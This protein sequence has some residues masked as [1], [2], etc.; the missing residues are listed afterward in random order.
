MGSSN[1]RRRRRGLLRH[2]GTSG[3]VVCHRQ[4]DALFTA[5]RCSG[6]AIHERGSRDR[7]GLQVGGEAE[8]GRYFVLGDRQSEMGMLLRD[9]SASDIH[10]FET[11]FAHSPFSRQ[12]HTNSLDRTNLRGTLGA[13][14]GE[15]GAISVFGNAIGGVHRTSDDGA[16]ALDVAAASPV[17]NVGWLGIARPSIT[18]AD[19]AADRVERYIYGA[20]A[21]LRPVSLVALHLAA[22]A[23]RSDTHSE[24]LDPGFAPCAAPQCSISRETTEHVA[25]DEYAG[26]AGATATIPMGRSWVLRSD[27]GIQYREQR[28]LDTAISGNFPTGQPF[29]QSAGGFEE[30]FVDPHAIQRGVYAEEAATWNGRL[31]LTAAVHAEGPHGLLGKSTQGFP[32]I[33][34]SWIPYSHDMDVVRVHGAYGVSGELPIIQALS[35]QVARNSFFTGSFLIP[36]PAGM[37]YVH[38]GEVGVDATVARGRISGSAT[39]YQRSINNMALPFPHFDDEGFEVESF[40]N[41]TTVEN[42]SIELSLDVVAVRIPSVRWDASVNAWGNQNR[43]ESLGP[44]APDLV[45]SGF[46]LAAGHPLYAIFE[47]V[48][49]FRDANHDGVIEPNEFTLGSAADQGSSLPTRGVALQNTLVLLGGRFRVGALVD[50]E[51]GNKLIDPL[52]FLQTRGGTSRASSDSQTPL[53][54]QAEALA[55]QL[56]NS[57]SGPYYGAAQDASFVRFRELSVSMN[58]SP[59]IARVLR[60]SSAAISLVARNLWLWTP[61]KRARIPRSTRTAI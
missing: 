50:Y 22:G 54:E 1:E 55:V 57:V 27:A 29:P 6:D 14:L 34:A 11:Q 25:T 10:N 56:N 33:A 51:G 4:R 32:R 52:H 18:F 53:A 45:P 12:L 60:T 40:L 41:G 44:S 26:D 19:E 43:V 3:A 23:D 24:D 61:Y 31:T 58:A 9:L 13:D 30:L 36:L 42:R 37:E 16:L 59:G 15:H 48:L 38:E 47:P 49:T 21:T 39:L 8:P 46:L 5:P 35:S 28:Q 2:L 20:T 17:R 7:F